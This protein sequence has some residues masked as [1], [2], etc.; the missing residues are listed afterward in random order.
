[1]IAIDRQTHSVR[2]YISGTFG[3]KMGLMV[4]STKRDEVRVYSIAK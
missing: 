2:G 4:E 3:K 1:M